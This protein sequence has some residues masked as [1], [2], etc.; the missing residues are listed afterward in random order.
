MERD[1][2]LSCG[3]TCNISVLSTECRSLTQ[4]HCKILSVREVCYGDCQSGRGAGKE[5][6]KLAVISSISNQRVVN[7]VCENVLW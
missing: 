7:T 4:F 2:S 5:K 3:V 1:F 6:I